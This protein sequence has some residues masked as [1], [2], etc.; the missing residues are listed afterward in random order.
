MP[1]INRPCR[2]PGC[3]NAQ[4][5][6]DHPEDKQYDRHRGSASS[7]GYDRRWRL[8][9]KIKLTND[10]LCERCSTDEQPVVAVIPHHI[11]PVDTHPELRL[12]MTNLQSLC[13]DCHEIVEGRKNDE[14]V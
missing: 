6:P 10:G 5:C 2:N 12:E 7:R 8:I 9:A 11:K 14:A 13:Y 1:T 3:P 4:P